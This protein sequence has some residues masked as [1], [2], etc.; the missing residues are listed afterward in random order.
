MIVLVLIA[1]LFLGLALVPNL[2]IRHVLRRHSAE[3]TDFPG[4]GAELARHLLHRFELDQVTVERGRAGQDHYNHKTRTISLS[5]GHYEG[6]SIAA[7][8]VAAHEVGHAIQFGRG[9]RI[10][11]LRLR[12]IP[13]AMQFK[14]IGILL[15]TLTPLIVLIA[16]SPSALFVVLG[17]GL[18]LQLVGVLAYAIV[19]PE[20]WD[21]SFAKALPLLA[22]GDY[23]SDADLPAVRQ[24]LQAAALT[25]VAAAL[26]ELVNIGRWALI[27]KR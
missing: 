19:L 11:R 16:R 20:E 15:M 6:R 26:S 7:V 5:P 2:W 1:L 12:W 27:L 24:V 14:R 9:E 4:T 17:L 10:S 3:R 22:D 23:V 18:L 25:Y 21:A 13:I 8:A